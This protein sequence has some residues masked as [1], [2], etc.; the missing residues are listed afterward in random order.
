MLQVN[1]SRSLPA[2]LAFLRDDA[3]EARTLLSDMLIGVTN[4]VRDR[5]AIQTLERSVLP[6]LF[7]EAAAACWRTP[8]SQAARPAKRLTRWR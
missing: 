8:G 1:G 5:E 6:G 2:Y 4:F 7:A 3:H